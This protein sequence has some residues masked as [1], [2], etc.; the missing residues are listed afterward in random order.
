MLHHYMILDVDV[1]KDLVVVVDIDFNIVV[2]F[3]IFIFFQI[4]K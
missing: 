2:I 4:L 3:V 1:G